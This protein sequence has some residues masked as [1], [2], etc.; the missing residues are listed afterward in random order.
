[1]DATFVDLPRQRNKKEENADIKKDA[2]P[3]DFAKKNDKGRRDRLSQKDTDARWTKKNNE[4]HY[5]FKNHINAD[6]KTKIITRYEVTDASVHD[7]QAI[8]VLIDESDNEA[9]AESA[10]RSNEIEA[11]IEEK[12]CHSQIHEKAYRNKPLTDKQKEANRAKSKIRARIEHIS[13][14]MSNSMKGITNRCIG[15]KRNSFQIG[16]MNLTYNLFRY[17]Q[18]V[19]IY[20]VERIRR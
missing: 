16:L 6:R 20:G 9:Y 14:F 4:T 19:R 5:G 11:L 18:L 15:M 3:L 2:I 12:G 7:S 8:E 17:E 1:V 10:Y 13:G